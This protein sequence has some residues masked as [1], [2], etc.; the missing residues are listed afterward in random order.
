MR[1]RRTG[2]LKLEFASAFWPAQVLARSCCQLQ[3][4]QSCRMPIPRPPLRAESTQQ[5]RRK[6]RLMSLPW[7]NALSR[8]RY[9]FCSPESDGALTS[10]RSLPLF[11]RSKDHFSNS[12]FLPT[13]QG[14]V[15]SQLWST[16]TETAPSKRTRAAHQPVQPAIL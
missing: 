11:L 8:Q 10:L 15:P 3:S 5:L 14:P 7:R 2:A 9:S 4:R 12:F 6:W 16:K 1:P 13:F